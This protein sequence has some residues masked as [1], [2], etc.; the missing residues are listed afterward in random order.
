MSRGRF[1]AVEGGEG[2][3][4][5]TCVRRLK[6]I[7][8]SGSVVFTREPGGTPLAEEVRRILLMSTEERSVRTEFLLFSAVRSE[9]LERVVALALEQ[10]IHVVTDRFDMSSWAYQV[11]RNGLLRKLFFDIR[12]V[13]AGVVPD[14]YIYFDLSTEVGLSRRM[15]AGAENT[16]DER[17]IEFHHKVG[18]GYR[19]A[20]RLFSNVIAI[21]ANLPQEEVQQ[22]FN[23]TVFR[24]LGLA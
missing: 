18:R 13:W 2:S 12:E 16:F 20:R 3:G 22:E 14:A 24:I 11:C 10:G 4:K 6:E 15:T 8:P 19:E 23:E 9:H 21:N 17:S 7:V 5:T 1:I